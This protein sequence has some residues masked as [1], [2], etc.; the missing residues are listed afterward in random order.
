MT[1]TANPPK[2]IAGI[3]LDEYRRTNYQGNIGINPYPNG[4]IV[5]SVSWPPTHSPA[6]PPMHRW[7]TSNDI[8]LGISAPTVA[9]APSI[10]EIRLRALE[11]TDGE[12][13][14]AEE[15]VAWVMGEGKK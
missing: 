5:G 1:Y 2:S 4:D 15:L 9:P 11:I 7:P 10:Q 6:P 3:D 14:W 12:V 8:G 13:S